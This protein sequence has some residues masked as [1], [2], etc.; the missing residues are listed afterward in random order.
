[1]RRLLLSAAATALLLS[2]LACD[3]EKTG[4]QLVAPKMM[5][6]A[7]LS[8]PSVEFSP[9][10][11]AGLDAGTLPDGGTFGETVTIPGQTMAFVFFGTRKNEAGQPSPISEG[12]D[13]RLE[14][15]GESPVSLSGGGQG[16]YSRTSS[17]EPD[18][19][20][21]YR[22]GASYRFVAAHEGYAHVATVEEAPL[23]EKLDGLHPS[24]GYV[25]HTANQGL[26][27][28]RPPVARGETRNMG[29]VTVFA[30]DSNGERGQEPTYTN[31]PDPT[32]PLAILQFV[33]MPE[34][35]T[36]ESVTIPGSAF[37]QPDSTYLVVFH[38]ANMGGP[39]SDNLFI[40]STVLVGT[41]DVGVVHTQ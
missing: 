38:T 2:P 12:A 5:V 21:P 11:M 8:T 13:L 10:A 37:P 29:F 7:L 24:E 26:T 31:A 17:S 34:K 32:D 36:G 33:A 15:Q 19:E 35:W 4:N 27:L 25:Q 39:E 6:G 28:Q 22:S 40:G 23:Q 14:I 9:A 3:V 18:G 30:L 20:I 16:V 41:A 1:M